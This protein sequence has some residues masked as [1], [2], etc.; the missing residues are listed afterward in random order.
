MNLSVL[1]RTAVSEQ[2]KNYLRYCQTMVENCTTE[3]GSL[4]FLLHPPSLD[5][6]GLRS[7]VVSYVEGFAERSGVKVSQN[8]AALVSV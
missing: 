3:I 4:S 2:N 1:G 5:E 7:A 8:A 6:N